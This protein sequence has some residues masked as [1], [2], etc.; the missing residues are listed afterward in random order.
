[1]GKT[2]NRSKHHPNLEANHAAPTPTSFH[3]PSALLS[4][5]ENA[6]TLGLE[7]RLE[8]AV[9]TYTQLVTEASRILG[10]THE[11]TLMGC[12]ELGDVYTRL[13]AHTQAVTSYERA[14]AGFESTRGRMDVLT[15]ST[16]KAL[17]ESYMECERYV[18]SLAAYEHRLEW[19]VQEFGEGHPGALR[20]LAKMGTVH[21]LGSP[22]DAALEFNEGVLG[23]I[24]AVMGEQWLAVRVMYNLSLVYKTAGQQD[25]ADELYCLGE[26]MENRVR[27]RESNVRRM[28][29]ISLKVSVRA[30]IG[31]RADLL[32]VVAS[33]LNSFHSLHGNRL[34]ICHGDK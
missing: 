17:A 16:A 19:I 15:V 6:R 7:N 30:M 33:V 1:M 29:G 27:D 22:F 13:G 20:V 31:D 11:F 14:A 9:T 18:E 34:C 3:S 24:L 26:E 10:E 8:V 25:K 2:R 4:L 32:V 12:K 21:A 23:R 5:R 28:W